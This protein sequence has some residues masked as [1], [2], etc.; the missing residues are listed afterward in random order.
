MSE[1]DITAISAMVAAVSVVAG[2]VYF[3]F[4]FRQQAKIRQTDLVMRLYS[5]FGSEDFQQAAL[6]VMKLEYKDY[7]DYVKKYGPPGSE[8]PVP[9]AIIKIMYFFEGVGILLQRK[10]ID[11]ELVAQLFGPNIRWQWRKIK[12][13][14]E[15]FR[16]SLNA[17]KMA[18]SFEYLYN[19]MIKREQKVQP[20][21]AYYPRRQ[22]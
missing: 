5:T 8:E 1:F 20:P 7:N 22:T 12:P 6:K 11:I 2:V 17:P 18:N 19:Q 10:L 16:K 15:S 13:L 9:I 14:I 21:E 4:Q 3:V